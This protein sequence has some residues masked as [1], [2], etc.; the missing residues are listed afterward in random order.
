MNMSIFRISLDIHD[1]A[2]QLCFSVKKGD[3]SRRLLI[4]LTENGMPYR[5]GK[6]CYAVFSAKKADNTTIYNDCIIKDNTI[7]YDMTDQT[8]SASGRCECELILYG[9]NAEQLTS[10][11]FS[12]IVYSPVHSGSEIASTSEY[13]AL[14]NLVSEGNSLLKNGSAMIEEMKYKLAT[15]LDH[16]AYSNALLCNNVGRNFNLLDLSPIEHSIEMISTFDPT[17]VG[18]LTP[19]FSAFD[20]D[21][22]VLEEEVI[23]EYFF[24][25]ES[26]PFVAVDSDGIETT[27]SGESAWYWSLN[28]STSGLKGDISHKLCYFRS[29]GVNGKIIF[30]VNVEKAGWYAIDYA[31][32]PHG[33]SYCTVQ[34]YVNNKCSGTPISHKANIVIDGKKSLASQ[35]RNVTA[36]FGYFDKGDNTISF[37]VT[38]NKDNG[39]LGNSG[40]TLDYIQLLPVTGNTLSIKDTTPY[41]IKS[42]SGKTMMINS[43]REISVRYNKDINKFINDITNAIISLGG[44]VT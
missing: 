18:G 12:V 28:L 8:T 38:Q 3:T 1:E 6:D 32:R 2:S 19:V 29:G 27:T 9:G 4:T 37:I 31:F 25:A 41:Y 26:T 36:G 33:T 13:T 40:F 10:P 39:D 44:E 30:T 23:A 7:I 22:A 43:T 20:V 21:Y 5:I 24:E 34:V 17:P 16:S 11:R 15:E 42:L 14:A 35:M